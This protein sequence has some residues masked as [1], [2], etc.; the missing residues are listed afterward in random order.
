LIIG[1][2]LLYRSQIPLQKSGSASGAAMISLEK[3]TV[4][5]PPKPLPPPQSPKPAPAPTVAAIT[6]PREA[7]VPILAIQPNKPTPPIPAKTPAE[8]HQ[9]IVH[10][11]VSHP[12]IT[13]TPSPP[14]PA[15]AMIAS[16]Y[17][18]GPSV[19]PHPPYPSEARELGQTG[20]VVMNVEFDGRGNIA[21]A[22]VAQSSG[23]PILDSETR[24]FI[25]THWHSPAYAGQAV[26][27]PVQ[28]TLENL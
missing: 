14:R 22:V 17:A 25:R 21:Q 24:S 11:V 26:S 13:T 9:A 7:T 4:V 6:P 5:S 27:V 2:T 28:Y 15:A 20:T 18:P 1:L 3:I 8:V 16:S 10:T 23:V 19:M 12:A